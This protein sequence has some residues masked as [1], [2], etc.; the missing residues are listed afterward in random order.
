MGPLRQVAIAAVATMALLALTSWT[1]WWWA[2]V[3]LL[4]VASVVTVSDNGLA[5]TAIAERAGPFW[6]GRGLGIQNTGQN[7]TIAAVPPV[8]GVL[9]TATGFPAVYLAAAA[10]AAVAIPLVPVGSERPL[11]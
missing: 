3:P 11:E 1:H 9:I 2:A 4:V 10:L 6:S 8:F 5:F 7:L